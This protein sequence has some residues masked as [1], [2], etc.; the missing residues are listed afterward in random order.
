MLEVRDHNSAHLRAFLSTCPLSVILCRP[1]L[2]TYVGR[3][4]H[5]VLAGRSLGRWP[6]TSNATN[7]R[8]RQAQ[9]RGEASCSSTT[10][11]VASGP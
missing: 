6:D 11:S 1:W 9:C 5:G 10:R 2:R 4:A 7:E 3:W 8:R